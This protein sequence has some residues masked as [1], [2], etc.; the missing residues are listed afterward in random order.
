MVISL[1][2]IGVALYQLI[3]LVPGLACV[4]CFCPVVLKSQEEKSRVE[5]GLRFL[6]RSIL[7]LLLIVLWGLYVS[8]FG[9]FSWAEI[10]LSFTSEELPGTQVE[11]FFFL[12]CSVESLFLMDNKYLFLLLLRWLLFYNSSRR[13][14]FVELRLLHVL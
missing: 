14:L 2:S 12:R 13:T 1:C 7:L 5:I 10:F 9:L 6:Y 4:N 11:R 3:V 8:G